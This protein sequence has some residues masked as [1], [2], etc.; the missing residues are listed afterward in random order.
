MNRQHRHG[1]T[2]NLGDTS[3]HGQAKTQ[4]PAYREAQKKR[5][6]L[7]VDFLNSK[8]QNTHTI[9]T[10]ELVN[11]F[12]VIVK[13]GTGHADSH[14]QNMVAAKWPTVTRKT[15]SYPDLQ[16]IFILQHSPLQDILN[17]RRCLKISI[18]L[19][20]FMIILICVY[21]LR[22]VYPSRYGTVFGF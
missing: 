20:C 13:Y 17:E 2:E 21:I 4:F 11:G 16:D 1:I 22:L 18:I 19:V 6:D 7:F 15:I 3:E 8:K 9:Q 10:E 14:L 12:K 5:L